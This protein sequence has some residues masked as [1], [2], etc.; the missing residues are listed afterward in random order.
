MLDQNNS[1]ILNM[2]SGGDERAI[3]ILFKTKGIVNQR[4]RFL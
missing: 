1:K 4:K 3:E 2:E